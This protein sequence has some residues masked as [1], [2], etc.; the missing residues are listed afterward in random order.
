M[1][2]SSGWI[3]GFGGEGGFKF[4]TVEQTLKG[5]FGLNEARRLNPGLFNG[6]SR[7]ASGYWG[8]IFARSARRPPQTKY[9]APSELPPLA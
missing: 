9:L 3:E 6:N 7:G 8:V 2:G 4:I 5:W 1:E